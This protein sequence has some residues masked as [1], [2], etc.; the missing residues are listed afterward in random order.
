[1]ANIYGALGI[2][3]TDRLFLS[4]L[5]QTVVYNAVNE[6][7]TAHSAELEAAMSVFV[8]Y[9]TSNY[10]L[11]YKGIGGG[12]LQRRGGLAQSGAVK[13]YGGWD[14]ALPLEDFGAQIAAN[15]I[16]FA[17]MTPQELQ[18]HVDNVINQDIRTVRFEVLKALLNNTQRTF[19]DPLWGSLLVEPLANGDAVTFPPI[20][21]AEAEATENHYLQSGYAASAIS[22]T[23]DPYATIVAEQEE[24]S[25]SGASNIAVFI[26]SAQV[27]KTKALTDF[28]ESPDRFITP[29]AL[30]DVVTGL[31]TNLPGR[32]IGRVSNAWVVVWQWMPANYM[33]GVDL[34]GQAPLIQRID[35]A[36]TGLGTGLQLVAESDVYPFT[37][38]HYRHRFGVGVGNRL[39]GVVMELGT[40]GSYGI[41]SGYS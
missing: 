19:V 38:S 30:S 26:N 33:V 35:P 22:D 15:D 40:D 18:I 13:A 27:A 8:A 10:K 21:G 17:Y 11:R 16:A 41:P 3:D 25:L 28:D 24:H 6:V 37:A 14:V 34:A 7:L 5:G 20:V 36:D 31:P 23:N 12:Y 1:M 29:G 9:T 2:Q 4:T 32:V 39:N